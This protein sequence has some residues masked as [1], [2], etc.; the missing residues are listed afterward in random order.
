MNL[1]SKDDLEVMYDSVSHNHGPF[2]KTASSNSDTKIPHNQGNQLMSFDTFGSKDQVSQRDQRAQTTNFISQSKVFRNQNIEKISSPGFGQGQNGGNQNISMIKNANGDKQIVFS[3][4]GKNEKD[5]PKQKG[6]PFGNNS[7]PQLYEKECESEEINNK[8]KD[9]YL[10]NNNIRDRSDALM[11]SQPFYK[12][13]HLQKQSE[14][15]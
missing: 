10:F 7:D 12:S 3:P 4:F 2:S 11:Q 9:K 14:N 15:D 5:D 8:M 1:K 13:T 6:N